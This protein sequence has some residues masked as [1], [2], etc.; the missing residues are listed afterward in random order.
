M[1][2]DDP[3]IT[4]VEEPPLSWLDKTYVPSVLAGLGTTGKHFPTKKMTIPYPEQRHEPEDRR[5]YRGVHR[6]NRDAQADHVWFI[7]YQPLGFLLFFISALAEANRTPFDLPECEQELVGGYHTEYSS[8]KWALFFFGEYTHVVVISLMTVVLFF[9]GWDLPWVLGAAQPA[10]AWASLG[11][12]IAKVLVMMVKTFLVILLIMWIR[13]TL[14]R[15]RYD[16][17]MSLAWRVMIPLGLANLLITAVVVHLI[18]S[19]S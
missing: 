19:G 2:P 17:L 4:W 16:Q 8:M 5:N 15:F 18:R 3:N 14:P 13:W 9:G 12:L 6:L 10:G 7:F 1:K 11:V